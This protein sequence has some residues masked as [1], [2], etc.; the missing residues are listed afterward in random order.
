MKK[1]AHKLKQCFT[2]RWCKAHV[3]IYVSRLPVLC[4]SRPVGCCEQ[5]RRRLAVWPQRLV[6]YRGL[7]AHAGHQPVRC[8]WRNS[9]RPPSN[10]NDKRQSGERRQR[11]WANQPVRGTVL[12]LQVRSGVL[13]R[14]PAVRR[15]ATSSMLYIRCCCSPECRL[16]LWRFLSVFPR[17]FSINM[18]PFGIKVACIEPGFFKTN[19]TDMGMLKNNVKKLWDRLPQNVRDD[20]GLDFY[21]RCELLYLCVT[22]LY[23]SGSKHHRTSHRY[24]A[25][26]LQTINVYLF[27]SSPSNKYISFFF[28]LSI[29][30]LSIHNLS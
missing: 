20:Y 29:H 15:D 26:D 28:N 6:H 4:F 1:G 7:Q 13:Q 16:D 5:R 18:A 27:V 3:S 11:V 24:R 30:N 9:E 21:E 12:H 22:F 19:V 14:Q 10:K 25:D 17:G 2:S 23:S 8:N